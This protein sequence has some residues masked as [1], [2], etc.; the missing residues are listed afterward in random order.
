MFTNVRRFAFGK[1]LCSTFYPL[2]LQETE[3]FSGLFKV[4]PLLFPPMGNSNLSSQP[5]NVVVRMQRIKFQNLKNSLKHRLKG[6]VPPEQFNSK[7]QSIYENLRIGETL[8]GLK[9]LRKNASLVEFVL[10]FDRPLSEEEKFRELA[11]FLQSFFKT[12]GVN[13]F[14]KTKDGKTTINPH[15]VAFFFHSKNG[16]D[17]IHILIV[18]RK[19]DGKKVNISPGMFRELLQLYLPPEVYHNM[20][21]KVKKRKKKLGAYPL[22]VIR[23]LETLT[24]DPKFVKELVQ[25]CRNFGVSKTEF[26]ELFGDLNPSSPQEAKRQITSILRGILDE[27]IEQA[28]QIQQKFREVGEWD[29]SPGL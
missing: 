28:K 12:T 17:H 19:D 21:S 1:P 8:G 13:P 22:W 5:F 2:P 16:K 18:P 7:I 27:K 29:N 6:V 25:T 20:L 26:K 11:K 24:Q 15:K 3:N 10:A 14:L 4:F 9:N 23:K